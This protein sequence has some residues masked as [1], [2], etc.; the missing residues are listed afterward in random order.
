MPTV[1]NTANVQKIFCHADGSRLILDN[2]ETAKISKERHDKF[3]HYFLNDKD[4]EVPIEKKLL[5]KAVK[6]EVEPTPE[7]DEK[8]AD[9]EPILEPDEKPVDVEPTPEP[10]KPEPKKPATKTKATKKTKK[11]K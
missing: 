1:T 3:S 11:N 8:P 9:E 4:I 6:V 5:G 2:N 7:P 10:E